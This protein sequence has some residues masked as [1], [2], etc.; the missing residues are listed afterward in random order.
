VGDVVKPF[1]EI[2]AGELAAHS[3][4]SEIDSRDYLLI[5]ELLPSRGDSLPS[6]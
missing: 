2:H 6:A 3:L 5:R 1:R 4:K